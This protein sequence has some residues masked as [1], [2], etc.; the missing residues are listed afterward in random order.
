M[1]GSQK[2]P[3]FHGYIHTP[4]AYLSDSNKKIM[5][6]YALKPPLFGPVLAKRGGEFGFSD[7]TP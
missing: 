2:F 1:K 7:T 4:F 3:V 6:G 5:A